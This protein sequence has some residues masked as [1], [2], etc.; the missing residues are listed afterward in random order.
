MPFLKPSG[1]DKPLAISRW[2]C[3]SVVRAPIAVQV[4]RSDRYCGVIGSS[5]SVAVGRPV[6][7]RYS[8][9]SRAMCRP[10]SIWKESSMSGSLINPFQPTVVRGFS[11]YTR[12][13]R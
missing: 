8:N 4:I 10:F 12:M 7:A 1:V 3:D 2:V 11:K 13:M 9:S 5:A 6:S